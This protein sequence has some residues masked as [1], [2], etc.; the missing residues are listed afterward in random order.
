ML[1]LLVKKRV[2][3]RILVEHGDAFADCLAVA[4]GEILGMGPEPTQNTNHIILNKFKQE[5]AGSPDFWRQMAAGAVIRRAVKAWLRHKRKRAALKVSQGILG[6]IP[7][8]RTADP[9]ASGE[10]TLPLAPSGLHLARDSSLLNSNPGMWL[11]LSPALDR[12]MLS[13][14]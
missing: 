14:H 2:I 9:R 1:Q 10:P 4:L 3:Y 11:C 12:N 6:A 7:Y 13:V 8:E 5:A